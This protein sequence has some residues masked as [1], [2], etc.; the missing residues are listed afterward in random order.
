MEQF[1]ESKAKKIKKSKINVDLDTIMSELPLP[2]IKNTLPFQIPY[3]MYSM[4]M[5]TPGA[6]KESINLVA[7]IRKKELEKKQK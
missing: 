7:D 4:I 5:G 6:I 1:F 3:W 2:S